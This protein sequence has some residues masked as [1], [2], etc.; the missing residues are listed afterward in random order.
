MVVGVDVGQIDRAEGVIAIR[1]GGERSRDDPVWVFGQRTGHAGASGTELFLAGI[2]QVRLL[3]PRGRRAGGVRR[4]ARG[5]EL[6]LQFGD[7]R[8]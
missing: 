5:G 2:G 4:L 8:G 1:A 7:A 6:G 3:V